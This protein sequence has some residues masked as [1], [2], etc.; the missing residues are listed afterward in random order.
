M[1]C[2]E[3][4]VSAVNLKPQTDLQPIID[5]NSIRRAETAMLESPNAVTLEDQ[6]FHHFAHEVYGRELRIPAGVAVIGKMHKHST[7]NILAGGKLA[8]TTP[9]GPKVLEAPAIFVSPAG[10]K[11]LGIAI[12]D[13]VFVTA[14]ATSET[15]PEKIVEEMTVPRDEELLFLEN[16]P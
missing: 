9:D 16:L 4:E 13:C 8:V 7:L 2:L 6:T 12:T 5:I 11:K 15:D 14:H 10:C 3:L 1:S